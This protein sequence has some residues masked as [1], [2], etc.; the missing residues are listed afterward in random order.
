MTK[1]Q[2]D[3]FYNKI[4]ELNQMDIDDEEKD[5]ATI[6]EIFKLTNT[7][8]LDESTVSKNVF[9]LEEN[10]FENILNN[11]VDNIREN[12]LYEYFEQKG[13][14]EENKEMFLEMVSA[15]HLN[16][17]EASRYI[18]ADEKGFYTVYL[19]K[20]TKNEDYML[21][22]LE[23]NTNMIGRY[24]FIKSESV[25]FIKKVLENKNI[26]LS[27]DEK[28]KIIASKGKEF[29][30]ECLKNENINLSMH[31][32]YQL[33]TSEGKEFIAECI[34]NEELQ[35]NEHDKKI[36]NELGKIK[37]ELK[38]EETVSNVNKINSITKDEEVLTECI[39]DKSLNLSND[40]RIS[41]LFSIGDDARK[42]CL[43]NES[44]PLDRKTRINLIANTYDYEFIRK[45]INETNLD[46]TSEESFELIWS[47]N[48]PSYIKECIENKEYDFSTE[49]T[50]K[51]ILRTKDTEFMKESLN[52]KE[53]EFT[54]YQ[55]FSLIR[56]TDDSEYIQL[57]L[58]DE[59]I[60]FNEEEKYE[61]LRKCKKEER[62]NIL[63]E[64]N[65]VELNRKS[66]VL[67]PKEDILENAEFFF[68]AAEVENIEEKLDLFNQIYETNEKA[69]ETIDFRIFKDKYI[70]TFGLDKINLITCFPT[71]QDNIVKLDEK[72]Y[73]VFTKIMNPSLNDKQKSDWRYLMVNVLN[74]IDDYDQII[75]ESQNFTKQDIEEL[76][77]IMQDKN[78]CN[79]QNLEQLRN[80]HQVKKQECDKMIKADSDIKAKKEVLLYKV[81]GQDMGY[82]QKIVEKYAEDIDSIENEDLKD[83]VKAL[84]EILEIKDESTLQKI[85]KEV[86]E[87]EKVDKIKT[88]AQ[89]KEEYGKLFDKDL[90]KID[91]L[92]KI[93]DNVF[94]AG[95]DFKIIMTSLQAFYSVDKIDDYKKNWNR[96]GLS[97]PHIC[98]SY[99]RQDKILTAPRYGICYGFNAMNPNSLQN[100]AAVDIAS[101]TEG[102]VS[103]GNG[104]VKYYNPDNQINNTTEYNEMNYDRIQN[105]VKVQPNY[106]IVFK[107]NGET[108]FLD[109]AQ[110]ASKDWGEM[111]IVV[112]DIDK[113]LKAEKERVDHMIEEYRTGN[114]N[115]AKDI[116]QKV[117]NNRTGRG[118]KFAEE[119]D[120]TEFEE[121][122]TRQE[123]QAQ[124]EQKV[125]EKSVNINDIKENNKK[126]SAKERQEEV[127]KM[128]QVYIRNTTY[129]RRS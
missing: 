75:N 42:Q 85:Y 16:T 22:F 25:D 29:I 69:L 101:N 12:G 99:I 58:T 38:K 127:S 6:E 102:I 41:L 74:N 71:V 124:K 114:K 50:Y 119:I 82:T 90:L 46:L 113:C 93:G 105:G 63:K 64:L 13:L 104:N 35:L 10:D 48:N 108:Q 120:L 2:I 44:I 18:K 30:K 21:S 51:L 80:F 26:K 61:L 107:E 115:L 57:C 32:K 5:I 40:E 15:T 14:E 106:I 117:K 121:E 70:E 91:H 126:V 123:A 67:L 1:E 77:K 94:D 118:G 60:N 86:P 96:P 84:K 72:Q 78:I 73:E 43:S 92:E 88:E 89:L 76:T 11:V 9:E 129:K 100:S 62:V 31:E 37:E 7:D 87:L 20:A 4:Q 54:T 55:K 23:E 79:I 111:P 98:C 95:T 47:T 36:L 39:I 45:Y 112:V 109:E 68:Q 59:K 65:D 53:L 128:K 19:L 83:Y 28:C 97:S 27:Q 56:A 122:I 116:V 33:I 81:F 8:K 125:E 24:E 66:V 52:D 110:K 103:R 17:Q 49:Q 3:N 34:A